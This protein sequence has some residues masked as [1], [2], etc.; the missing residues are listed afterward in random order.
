MALLYIFLGM[1]YW[2]LQVLLWGDII[3]GYHTFDDYLNP[4]T[5]YNNTNN[6]LITII[7]TVLRN[8]CFS[9]TAIFYWPYKVLTYDRD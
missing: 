3:F 4:I 7:L 9:L 2:G 8:L 1:A 5:I 6:I